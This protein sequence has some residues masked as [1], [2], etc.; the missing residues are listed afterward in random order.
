M[1]KI[2]EKSGVKRGTMRFSAHTVYQVWRWLCL[3]EVFIV[4]GERQLH[5]ASHR[6]AGSSSDGPRGRF[7]RIENRLRRNLHLGAGKKGRDL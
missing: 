3:R 4:T 5:Q 7:F 6:P 2:D 1:E